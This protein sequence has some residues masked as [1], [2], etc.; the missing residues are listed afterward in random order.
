MHR[1]I[2][3]IIGYTEI[4]IGAATIISSTA[5]QYINLGGSHKKPENVYFFVVIASLAAITLGTGL[6]MDKRWARQLLVFFSGYIVLTKMMIYLGLMSME[7]SLI[8]FPPRAIIDAISSTYHILVIF[9]L[10][11]FYNR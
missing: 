3:I 5:I 10:T 6:I 4:S 2:R 1:L 8:T 9:L 11:L 7:G